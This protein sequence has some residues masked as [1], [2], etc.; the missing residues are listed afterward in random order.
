MKDDGGLR[1]EAG[2]RLNAQL[3]IPLQHPFFNLVIIALVGD[4]DMAPDIRAG[5]LVETAHG[6]GDCVVVERVPKQEGAAGVAEAAADFFRGLVP[7][8]MVFAVDG[9]GAGRH[10]DRGPVMTGLL[11]ALAAVA[12]VGLGQV[13]GDF[14]ID[15]AAEAG[16]LVHIILPEV[17]REQ[18]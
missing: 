7:A 2:N 11:A 5:R 4:E 9:D 15:G 1:G 10:V 17:D 16:T 6:D 13:A 3:S 18:F 8:D 12:G 14:D